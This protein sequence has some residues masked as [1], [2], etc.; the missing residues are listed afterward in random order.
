MSNG[1]WYLE[2]LLVGAIG[3]SDLH[4]DAGHL[5]VGRE[6]RLGHVR[7]HLLR[8]PAAVHVLGNGDHQDHLPA[9]GDGVRH[10]GVILLTS[11][12]AAAE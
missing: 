12:T 5:G 8:G 7:R 10:A 2:L 9:D 4:P 3:P 6:D 11:G 1:P